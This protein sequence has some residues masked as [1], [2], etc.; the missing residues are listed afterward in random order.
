MSGQ[1][2]YPL[3]E[4]QNVHEVEIQNM[5]DIEI[6]EDLDDS[7]SSLLELREKLA[8][9][10]KNTVVYAAIAESYIYFDKEKGEFSIN[11]EAFEEYKLNNAQNKD[12]YSSLDHIRVKI[13]NLLKLTFETWVAAKTPHQNLADILLPTGYFIMPMHPTEEMI[14]KAKEDLEMTEDEETLDDRIVFAFQAMIREFTLS[15]KSK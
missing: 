3:Q 1:N 13:L 9:G 8:E 11:E 5:H 12:L 14:A 6:Q 15:L 7:E 10:F 4:V 2:E